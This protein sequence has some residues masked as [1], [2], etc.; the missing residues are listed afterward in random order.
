MCACSGRSHGY[1]CG[2][3]AACEVLAPPE[4]AQIT[5]VPFAR[6]PLYAVLPETHP[7]VRKHRVMLRDLAADQRILFA[8]Q[9]HPIIRDTI[10]ETARRE[11]IA[12]E[13]V[14]ESFLR[15]HAPRRLP[16]KQM[17]RPAACLASLRW[18]LPTLV[19]RAHVRG[20]RKLLDLWAPS[21]ASW[22]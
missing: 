14:H 4:N 9:V 18:G 16:P 11:A 2:R 13:V 5:S 1:R 12:P 22:Y 21:K 15:K 10:L 20:R 7:S 6:T 8:K 3:A 19:V 17:S